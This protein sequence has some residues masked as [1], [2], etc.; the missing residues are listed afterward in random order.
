MRCAGAGKLVPESGF[1]SQ[2]WSCPRDYVLLHDE[3]LLGPRL[4]FLSIMW[5]YT[6]LHAVNC[7]VLAPAQTAVVVKTLRSALDELL[8]RR[9]AR[10]GESERRAAAPSAT[11]AASAAGEEQVLSTIVRLLCESERRPA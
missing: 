8:G 1:N 10:G 2:T 5:S 4:R 9:A 11:A 6:L 3:S 7:R